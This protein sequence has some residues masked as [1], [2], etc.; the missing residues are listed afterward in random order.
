VNTHVGLFAS[1][2]TQALVG[3]RRL[4]ANGSRDHAS[5]ARWASLELHSD[6]SGVYGLQV[7][8][9]A[10]RQRR[11]WL[12]TATENEEPSVRLVDDESIVVGIL[13]GLLTLAQHAVDRAATGGG[14]LVRA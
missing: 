11:E 8:D 2:F 7:A 13:S 9:L 10:E 5:L 14:V 4:L 6:G 3:R 1:V 12:G